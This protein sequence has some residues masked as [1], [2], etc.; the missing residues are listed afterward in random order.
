MGKIFAAAVC[1]F[2]LAGC[3]SSGTKVTPEQTAQFERGKTTLAEVVARL[4]PPNSTTMLGN[5]QT[6]IVYVY[7]SSSANAASFVPVVGLLAGGA[8]GTSNTATFTF[9]NRGVLVSS[10]SSQSMTEVNTGLLNQH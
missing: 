10:G 6:I 4:G 3:A 7:V 8:T 2:V 9:D 5:G 1:V